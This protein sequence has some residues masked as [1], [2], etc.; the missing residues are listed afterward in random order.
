MHF[1]EQ[2]FQFLTH[3]PH[4]YLF[5]IALKHG[6]P[7]KT[8]NPSFENCE[9]AQ[10]ATQNQTKLS[11]VSQD[12]KKPKIEAESKSEDGT[13]EEDGEFDFKCSYILTMSQ[14]LTQSLNKSDS[15]LDSNETGEEEFVF[16]PFAEM[17]NMDLT[18]LSEKAKSNPNPTI[19][20]QTFKGADNYVSLQKVF[21]DIQPN[22][23]VLYQSNMTAIRQLEVSAFLIFTAFPFL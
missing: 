19:L 15:L 3:G 14:T 10:N 21:E 5:S 22:F 16:E 7:F 12:P 2:T 11:Q 17:E 20:I 4:N 6:I 1:L 9:V 8:I 18:Q 13:K 23:V